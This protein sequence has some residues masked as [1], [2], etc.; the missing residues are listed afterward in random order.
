[1]KNPIKN[2]RDKKTTAV[3][4]ILM[5]AAGADA[6]HFEKL[7]EM[8]LGALVGLGLLF[9]FSPDTALNFLKKKTGNDE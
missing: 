8:A 5:I 6:W 7:S 2:I 1:M 9:I 4:L 3:G